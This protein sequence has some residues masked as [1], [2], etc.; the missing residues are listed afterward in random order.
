M[1]YDY[2]DPAVGD[3]I[4]STHFP[5]EFTVAGPPPPATQN[6]SML[7]AKC[8]G[9]WPCPTINEYR[10]YAAGHNLPTT[11]GTATGQAQQSLQ[12]RGELIPP[13]LP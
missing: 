5:V 2:G 3:L 7:C 8:Y 12:R 9:P 4:R 6:L 13:R 1:S 11:T 10:A